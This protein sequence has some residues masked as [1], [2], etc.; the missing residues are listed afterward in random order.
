MYLMTDIDVNALRREVAGDV[1]VPADRGWDEARR[2]WNLA[3]DQRPAAVVRPKS[4]A[5]VAAAVRFASANGMRIA[6]QATGHN[7][8][9]LASL[10]RSLL[11]KTDALRGVSIDPD[12]LSA[13]VEGGAQWG[14]VAAPASELGLAGLAGSS[15]DVGVVGY[16]VGGGL[17]LGLGRKHGLAANHVLAAEVVTA[18]GELVRADHRS[19]PDLFWAIRGGGGN[20]G[21]ITALEFRLFELPSVY[22]GVLAW[23]IE[24]APDVLRRWRDWTE[25]TDDDVT[26][27]FRLMRLPDMPEIPDPVRGRAL[28]VIDGA[29]AGGEEAG[30][31]ALEPLREL[32]PE[33]DMFT[34][35]PPIGLS[36]IHMDP[37][38]PVPGASDHQVLGRLPDEAIDRVLEAA[39]PGVETP[40]LMV[41]L[42]QLGGALGRAPDRAGAL[43]ALA[44]RFAMFSG[45]LPIDAATAAV[46]DE[47]LAGLRAAMAPFDARSPYLNFAERPT[48]VASAFS[49]VA[50]RRLGEVKAAYDP[51]GVFQANHEIGPA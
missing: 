32:E 22:A 35:M 24:A 36:Y 37:P 49:D 31:R 51:R 11:V 19:E 6:P 8:G 23:P 10:E 39:G 20:F 45:G 14:D 18:D 13:R 21:V 17:S 5:D 40:L 7:A 44:G 2:A 29:H 26:T 33:M 46:I 48:D 9:P 43:G 42:R 3:V 4:A 25:Q 28:V 16:H 47:H 50:A 38:E 1:I 12:A 41:E 34:I 27:S 30:I 15:H